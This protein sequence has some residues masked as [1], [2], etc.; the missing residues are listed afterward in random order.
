MTPSSSPNGQAPSGKQIAR[1]VVLAIVV[2]AVLLVTAVLPAEYG[3]DPTGIGRA[4]GLTKL[5]APATRTIE[6]K[7]VIGG[8][9]R[10]R[11]MPIPSPGEPTPLPNPAVHQSQDQPP[12]T[13][14]VSLTL[15]VD[16][17]T[18]I[19]AVMQEAKVILYSWRV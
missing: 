16:K 2:A 15:G 17:E 5:H 19:K 4:L 11:E 8:N 9:E 12:Q 13:R 1:S 18:E 7:D 3:I 14:T 10:V 6:V